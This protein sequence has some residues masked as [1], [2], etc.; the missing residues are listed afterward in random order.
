M[1]TGQILLLIMLGASATSALEV[2][3]VAARGRPIGPPPE[4]EQLQ[5]AEAG[6]VGSVDD[7]PIPIS[8]SE[9]RMSQLSSP[10]HDLPILSESVQAMKKAEESRCVRG[11]LGAA[12]FLLQTVA[13]GSGALL[14]VS[15]AGAV[16]AALLIRGKLEA[17]LKSGPAVKQGT[18]K[19]IEELPLPTRIETTEVRMPE[20]KRNKVRNLRVA[21]FLTD[22]LCRWQGLQSRDYG[23][24]LRDPVP[25]SHNPKDEATA[26]L[27]ETVEFRNLP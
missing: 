16:G 1:G 14:A 12:L 15:C 8:V 26:Q 23:R 19:K 24:N 20:C 4:Q 21:T 7:G 22:L 18:S 11:P 13:S 17:R 2:Y 6:A 25:L 27:Q 3:L 9:F 5:R 10:P